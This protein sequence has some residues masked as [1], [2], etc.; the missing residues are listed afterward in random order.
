MNITADSTTT[1]VTQDKSPLETFSI[2]QHS[3]SKDDV[4]IEETNNTGATV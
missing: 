1:L 3:Y 2:K 4:R